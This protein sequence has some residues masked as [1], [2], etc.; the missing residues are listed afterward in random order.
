MATP[1]KSPER[2]AVEAYLREHEQE[3]RDMLLNGTLVKDLAL[4]AEAGSGVRFKWF[5]G[6]LYEVIPDAPTLAAIG[7]ANAREKREKQIIRE[8]GQF[9]GSFEEFTE[10][11]HISSTTLNDIIRRNNIRKKS[12]CEEINEKRQA[13]RIEKYKAAVGTVIYDKI[14]GSPLKVLEFILEGKKEHRPAVLVEC[15]DCG[16]VF[17][18]PAMKTI[19]CLNTYCPCNIEKDNDGNFPE[20]DK[21]PPCVIESKATIWCKCCSPECPTNGA[22]HVCCTE[23]YRRRIC[24]YDKC[25]NA[26][27]IC[28]KARKRTKS[29]GLGAW[30][31]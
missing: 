20:Q 1:T 24:E 15:L 19:S 5:Q 10:K 7:K 16:K 17:E 12:T 11:F 23:C 29:E 27:Q 21:Y 6:A 2:A 18:A 13:S 4:W 31:L 26:P 3:A 25:R 28:G 22:C 9:Q 8:Y 30:K 14:Y